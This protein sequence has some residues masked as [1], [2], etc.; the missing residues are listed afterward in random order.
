MIGHGAQL[1]RTEHGKPARSLAE[2]AK[3][4]CSP[5]EFNQG[6]LVCPCDGVYTLSPDGQHGLCTHHGRAH[7]LLPCLDIPVALA[8]GIE[9]DWFKNATGET[10]PGPIALRLQLRPER[11]RV[12]SL[13]P[14]PLP[15]AGKELAQ[16]QALLPNWRPEPLDDLPVPRGNLFTL[17]VRLPTEVIFRD[18]EARADQLAGLKK[19]QGGAPWLPGAAAAV[20][21]MPLAPFPAAMP[22]NAVAPRDALSAGDEFRD[23]VASL[24]NDYPDLRKYQFSRFL[25]KGLGNQIG[26]HVYDARILFDM[27]WAALF[28]DLSD[29]EPRRLELFLATFYLGP[30][31]APMYLAAPV[32]DAKIVDDFLAGLDEPLA[33]LVRQRTNLGV[34]NMSITPDYYKLTFPGGLSVRAFGVRAGPIRLRM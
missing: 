5:G 1:Y 13:V 34:G 11:Y 29:L 17:N 16:V 8:D 22:W 26:L 28:A 15:F 18:L 12:E 21:G 14:F 6:K 27:N 4:D 3:T 30:L 20:A 9:A 23:A 19:I 7:A 25:E 32:R 10:L 2:L 31:T 33:G 24:F